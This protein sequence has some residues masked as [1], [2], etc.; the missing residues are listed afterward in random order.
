MAKKPMGTAAA[1]VAFTLHDQ[2]M[3]MTDRIEEDDP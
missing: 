1:R 3:L 2:T